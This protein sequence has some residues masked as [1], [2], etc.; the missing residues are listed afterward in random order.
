DHPLVFRPCAARWGMLPNSPNSVP[1]P[2]ADDFPAL[3]RWLDA[4]LPERV[5]PGI[6]VRGLGSKIASPMGR[7]QEAMPPD[8][9]AKAGELKRRWEQ[10]LQEGLADHAQLLVE[11][12]DRNAPALEE[13]FSR[14]GRGDFR[15]IFA[16]YLNLVDY[17]RRLKIS[18]MPSIKGV[19]SS[20]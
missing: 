15:G 16:M 10:A 11:A 14:M 18:P 7:L 2:V 5:I 3:G 19:D 13:H 20:G 1:A 4:G 6:K 9:T 8:W 12:A 17:L